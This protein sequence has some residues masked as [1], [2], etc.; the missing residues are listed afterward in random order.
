[1]RA[2]CCPSVSTSWGRGLGVMRSKPPASHPDI[3]YLLHS[4]T[5][6]VWSSF[7][8]C[9]TLHISPGRTGPVI[10]FGSDMTHSLTHGL[11]SLFTGVPTRNRLEKWTLCIL[12]GQIATMRR[13]FY[14]VGWGE[15]N[16]HG[17]NPSF[18]LPLTRLWDASRCT[19][20][21]SV[22]GRKGRSWS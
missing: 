8:P 15:R 12:P 5:C 7:Q 21:D 1:M 22:R 20:G 10:L 19:A 2:D 18:L 13:L 6:W 4:G 14:N 11:E 17:C 9:F 3:I 16:K